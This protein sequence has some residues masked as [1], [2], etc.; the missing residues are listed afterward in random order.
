MQQLSHS[1]AVRP[2]GV[3]QLRWT[4]RNEGYG[5]P[6][7]ARPLQV[8]LE[9]G[10]LKRTATL[11]SIDVRRWESGLQTVEVKLRI[12]ANLPVGNY[13]LSLAMPD[14]DPV[15]ATRPVYSV[16]FANTG[17]WDAT[18]GVNVVVPQ[19]VVSDAAGGQADPSA[20]QFV[21]EL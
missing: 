2:G 16:Q 12:P 14:A 3:L 21:E 17:P 18:A 10:A 13:R 19:L 9:Q 5:A 6:F 15:L 8:Q 1:N 4:L 20:L 7:N 11:S